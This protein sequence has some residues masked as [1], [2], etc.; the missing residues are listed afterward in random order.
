MKN[1]KLDKFATEEIVNCNGLYG[2]E[3]GSDVSYLDSK[4][5]TSGKYDYMVPSLVD[6]RDSAVGDNNDKPANS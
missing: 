3:V 4:N 1:S 6:T 5:T 2:G